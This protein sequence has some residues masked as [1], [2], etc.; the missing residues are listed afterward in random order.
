M[1]SIWALN[2]SLNVWIIVILHYCIYAMPVTHWSQGTSWTE[3]HLVPDVLTIGYLDL[4]RFLRL[5]LRE[6]RRSNLLVALNVFP[7]VLRTP[8]VLS[9]GIAS[10]VAFI[11]SG[12]IWRNRSRSTMLQVM[13]CCLM[14][15]SH[16]SHKCWLITSKVQWHSSEGN[17]TWDTSFIKE[18]KSSREWRDISDNRPS[19]PPL[20][21]ML[22]I[23]VQYIPRN[24]PG[25]CC[26]LLCCG[27][28]IVHNEFTW[29]IYPYSSGLLCWHWGNR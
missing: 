20:S 5:G 14:A 21:T 15:P 4:T 19:F 22:V 29:G 2:I 24:M 12:T 17:S 26:A 6:I 13:T 9:G 27:Y 8:M 7:V 1:S 28:A 23:N 18:G 16:H 11:S 25:F 3:L 10:A